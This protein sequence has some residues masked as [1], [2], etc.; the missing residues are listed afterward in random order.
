MRD[1]ALIYAEWTLIV[2]TTFCQLSIG[3][4]IFAFLSASFKEYAIEK[5]LWIFSLLSVAI[6]GLAS[7]LHLQNP[8]N[9]LYTLTQLGTSWLSREIVCVGIFGGLLFLQVIKNT[10]FIGCL[11]SLAGLLLL[12]VMTMVYASVEEMPYWRFLGTLLAFLGTTLLLGGAVAF[13]MSRNAE[14]AC[15]KKS[16]IIAYITGLLFVLGSKL[17]WVAN[18][19]KNP[20]LAVPEALTQ[21]YFNLDVQLFFLLFGSLFLLVN[22]PI[23]FPVVMYLAFLLLL[24]AELAGR[25]LF[26]LAQFKVGV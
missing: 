3:M 24:G 21:G 19:L 20:D 15:L 18:T 11:A 5:K 25:A 13:I 17:S 12:Y 9:A 4:A 14:C 6:A 2:F 7:V 10:K 8:F 1:F 16:A 23:K 22:K 26:F